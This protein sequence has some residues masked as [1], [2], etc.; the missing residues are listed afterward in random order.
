M[1]AV[2]K[3]IDGIKADERTDGGS[4]FYDVVNNLTAS[5][6]SCYRFLATPGAF[7]DEDAMDDLNEL[8]TCVELLEKYLDLVES[9]EDA[10]A[11][12]ITERDGADPG[13][14]QLADKKKDAREIRRPIVYY[15]NELARKYSLEDARDTIEAEGQKAA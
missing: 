10:K 11:R 12:E 5:A 15:V 1:E 9:H 3:R 4:S 8:T 14:R 2:G 6:N 7:E 13:L